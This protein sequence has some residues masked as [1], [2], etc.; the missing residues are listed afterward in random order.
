MRI[1]AI[2]TN[3]DN[4][5]NHPIISSANGKARYDEMVQTADTYRRAKQLQQ[6]DMPRPSTLARFFGFLASLFSKTESGKVANT[7]ARTS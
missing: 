1:T 4:D 2:K 6:G 5:M 7:V 3:G